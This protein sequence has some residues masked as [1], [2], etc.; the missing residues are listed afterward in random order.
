[1]TLAEMKLLEF[2]RGEYSMEETRPI[3]EIPSISNKLHRRTTYTMEET[4]PIREIPSLSN[5][6]LK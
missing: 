6:R 5:A 1:M 4:G 3:R 2:L